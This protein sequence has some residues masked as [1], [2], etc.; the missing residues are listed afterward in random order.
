MLIAAMIMCVIACCFA[1]LIGCLAAD[2]DAFGL[3]KLMFCLAA[4]LVLAPL[5]AAWHLT[6]MGC[7]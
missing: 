2:R 1:V 6:A 4:A 5:V 3:A 7:S